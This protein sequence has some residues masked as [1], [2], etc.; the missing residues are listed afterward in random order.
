MPRWINNIPVP[1]DL[2]RGRAPFNHRDG[3]LG[4]QG[5]WQGARGNMAQTDTQPPHIK[6]PCFKCGKQG[7][8][9]Q[10]CCSWMQINYTSYINDQDNMIGIQ[11]PI[12]PSNLLSN[13]L[14]AFDSLPNDQ[15][16]KL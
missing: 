4:R 12:Q 6:G 7:H 2:F 10:E 8:F 3:Q 11:P 5:Q 14:T 15:K 16:D 9:T 1:M 13:T